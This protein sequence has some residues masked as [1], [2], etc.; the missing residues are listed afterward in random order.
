MSPWVEVIWGM[1]SR[2]VWVMLPVMKLRAISGAV[3]ITLSTVSLTPRAVL[4]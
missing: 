2:K 1:L 3:L 4:R